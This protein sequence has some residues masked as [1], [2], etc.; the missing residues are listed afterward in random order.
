VADQAKNANAI[1]DEAHDTGLDGSHP[2]TLQA[3]ML[4]LELLNVKAD[5]ERELGRLVLHCT[6]TDSPS[7]PP[8][9]HQLLR[10]LNSPSTAI[11]RR[12]PLGVRL[13]ENVIPPVPA[14]WSVT[15]IAFI[16]T[17]GKATARRMP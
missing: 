17:N 10:P 4:R 7:G 5:L 12:P 2:V 3:K 6:F 11:V 15:T 14:A 9:S 16:V 13:L 8:H 1:V